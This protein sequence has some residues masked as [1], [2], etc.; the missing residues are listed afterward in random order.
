MGTANFIERRFDARPQGE[1]RTVFSRPEPISANLWQCD[2]RVT[3]HDHD[4]LSRAYGLDGVQALLLA[5]EKVHLS[6]LAEAAYRKQDG[7]HE[8]G[9]LMWQGRSHLALPAVGT[10]DVTSLHVRVLGDQRNDRDLDHVILQECVP[11]YRK[12]AIIAAAALS[13]LGHRCRS[14]RLVGE[15]GNDEADPYLDTVLERI[16]SLV[17][18]G[19]LEAQGNLAEPRFSEVGLKTAQLA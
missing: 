19:D 12:V 4:L 17:A 14:T 6:L 13:A 16:E 5:M 2:Y 9:V 7:S 10:T 18:S 1:I 3:W 11:R 15:I 8:T